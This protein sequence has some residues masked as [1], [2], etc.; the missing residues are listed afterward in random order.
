M[1]AFCLHDELHHA[2]HELTD[3]SPSPRAP[4]ARQLTPVSVSLEP[5]GEV[6]KQLDLPMRR[7]CYYAAN[8]ARTAA[9]RATVARAQRRGNS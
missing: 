7:L 8:L 4:S 5:L 9:S 1:R 2:R 6:R 3:A